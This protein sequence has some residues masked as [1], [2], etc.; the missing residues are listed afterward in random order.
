M[1]EVGL[2]FPL[3]LRRSPEMAPDVFLRNFLAAS[4]DDRYA[5]V[6]MA[7]IRKVIMTS[8]TMSEML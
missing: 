6:G 5:T 1:N 3:F 8:A 2:A 4:E 7:T